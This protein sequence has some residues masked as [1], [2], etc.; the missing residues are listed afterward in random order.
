MGQPPQ[1]PIPPTPPTSPRTT[2]WGASYPERPQSRPHWQNACD[3]AEPAA[4]TEKTTHG[5]GGGLP[6]LDPTKNYVMAVVNCH[7]LSQLQS[8]GE[9]WTVYLSNPTIPTNPAN[10]QYKTALVAFSEQQTIA[11]F[12]TTCPS[13]PNWWPC[14]WS[15]VQYIT[16]RFGWEEV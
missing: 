1:S 12:A 13:I 4:P 11:E 3:L 10:V 7:C 2:T 5:G 14:D 16:A 9:G 8:L 6:F 15:D